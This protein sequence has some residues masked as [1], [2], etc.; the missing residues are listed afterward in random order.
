MSDEKTYP[1]NVYNDYVN[2]NGGLVADWDPSLVR[3]IFLDGDLGND[4]NAGYYDAPAGT[5]FTPADAFR[6]A[7]KTTHRINQIRP[8]V[9]AGR[10]VVVLIKPR[11]ALPYDHLVDGDGLGQEDRS[12]CNGY[13][14][15]IT[16]GSDL[17]NSAADRQALGM[18]N[19]IP[20]PN[21][22]GSWTL[23]GVAALGGGS[24]RLTIAGAALPAGWQLGR[25]RLRLQTGAGTIYAAAKWGDPAA[26]PDPTVVTTWNMGGA[27]PVPGDTIIFERPAAELRDF[28]EAAGA[29]CISSRASLETVGIQLT[30]GQFYIGGSN[31]TVAKYS[32]CWVDPSTG[33]SL[34]CE[35]TDASLTFD[36]LWIDEVGGVNSSFTGLGIWAPAGTSDLRGAGNTIAVSQST[37]STDGAPTFTGVEIYCE[38]F[39]ATKSALQAYT[40]QSATQL[41]SLSSVLVG[42]GYAYIEGELSIV[43]ADRVPTWV[44]RGTILS[45]N[46][47]QEACRF[48]LQASNAY[49]GAEPATPGYVLVGS[50]RT[51]TVRLNVSVASTQPGAYIELQPG[52]GVVI[53]LSY[54]SL[55]T[56]GFW[57]ETGIRV[58]S[59]MGGD[60]PYADGDGELPCPRCRVTQFPDFEGVVPLAIPAGTV[61]Y[62][63][64]GQQNRVQV[65]TLLGLSG[66]LFPPIGVTVTNA[67]S[68][69]DGVGGQIGGWV[70]AAFD[71]PVVA[72]LEAALPYPAPNAP[73]FLSFVTDGAV[74]NIPHWPRA[75]GVDTA[76]PRFLGRVMPTGWDNTRTTVY[77]SLTPGNQAQQVATQETPF[78]SV[79]AVKADVPG[80]FVWV[81]SG[82]VYQVDATIDTLV[83]AVGG[84]KLSV[85]GSATVAT[86]S[87]YWE[88]IEIAPANSLLTAGIVTALGSDTIYNGAATRAA[89]KLR[90]WI[91]CNG[92]G[93]LRLQFAQVV[94]DAGASTISSTVFSVTE[95][96]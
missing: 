25:Y 71:G 89:W 86:M 31:T 58:I 92:T 94:A 53:P 9:G 34:L 14:L 38:N 67:L 33:A 30:R 18:A 82:H 27:A 44:D 52:N 96:K 4:L 2:T 10:M 63:T 32:H 13:S 78:P 88:A 54:E 6:V 3:Y 17:T 26:V 28:R 11:A 7:V 35:A 39:S 43:G 29:R 95:Q 75:A 70:L 24:Y 23:T 21:L 48:D 73:L 60:L 40:F 66:E 57:L 80:V 69:T 45:S 15:M 1:N 12:L 8:P 85:D 62:A 51:F 49:W 47:A 46:Q 93:E 19:A 16:R 72:R 68:S 20:G 42:N 90:G 55:R 37:F 81:E 74:T 22:D 5:V 41:A 36:S 65:A 83:G 76:G 61:V 50:Q 87:L 77:L 79:T 84:V 64:P 91:R 56:T 59:T